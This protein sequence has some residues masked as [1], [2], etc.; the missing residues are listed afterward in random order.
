MRAIALALIAQAVA[1]AIQI[2]AV[3]KETRE[4]RTDRDGAG[5]GDRVDPGDRR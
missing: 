5:A 3:F 4:E 2:T 1:I